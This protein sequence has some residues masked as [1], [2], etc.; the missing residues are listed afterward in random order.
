MKAGDKC[1]CGGHVGLHCGNPFC[2][3]LTCSLCKT[4]FDP[5]RGRSAP[6]DGPELEPA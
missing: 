2:T 1:V 3:W 5:I 4:K 6:D